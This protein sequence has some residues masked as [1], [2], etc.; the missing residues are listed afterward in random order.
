MGYR[1]IP[2]KGFEG[3]RQFVP[4]NQ[5]VYTQRMVLRYARVNYVPDSIFTKGGYQANAE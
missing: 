2:H 4:P 5:S 3:Y 1:D